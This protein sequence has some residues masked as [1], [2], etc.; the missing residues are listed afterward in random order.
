M[1]FSGFLEKCYIL[2]VLDGTNIKMYEMLKDA[3][4]ATLKK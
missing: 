1:L 2:R 3:S 4:S